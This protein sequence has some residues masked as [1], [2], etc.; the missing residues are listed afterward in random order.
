M[1]DDRERIRFELTGDVDEPLPASGA[2]YLWAKRLAGDRFMIDNIPIYVRGVS[3]GDVVAAEYSEGELHFQ[4]VTRRGGHST[5]RLFLVSCRS[6]LEPPVKALW[7]S[8]SGLGCS[9]E[10]LAGGPLFAIDVPPESDI[11][12][13]YSELE[14]AE[15]AGIWDFEE[16]NFEHRS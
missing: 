14:R 5:Y 3:C 2:E 1:L 13:V 7:D 12:A 4:R 6:L 8:L 9:F 11:H 16:A 10:G 15:H